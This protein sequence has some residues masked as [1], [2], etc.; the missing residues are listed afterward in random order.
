MARWSFTNGYSIA[1][2]SDKTLGAAVIHSLTREQSCYTHSFVKQE[3]N[4][5]S[6]IASRLSKLTTKENRGWKRADMYSP[7]VL[8]HNCSIIENRESNHNDK[9]FCGT[10]LSLPLSMLSGPN[11]KPFS[12]RKATS[13]L[14][15][16]STSIGCSQWYGRLCEA[17]SFSECPPS[18][19]EMRSSS[20]AGRDKSSS[21]QKWMTS[22][23]LARKRNY[24]GGGMKCHTA[25]NLTYSI[26]PWQ[27]GF[28][29]PKI[30][31]VLS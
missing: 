22:C 2:Y 13:I 20:K 12:L 10:C 25:A 14:F 28:L 19:T 26:W 4:R 11:R 1:H 16:V 27:I 9:P 31:L 8:L 17:V 5:E 7:R 24:S 23:R 21:F 29:E 6:E 15:T 3:L 30:S 18:T